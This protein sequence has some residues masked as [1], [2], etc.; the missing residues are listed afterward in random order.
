M[1]RTDAP[2]QLFPAPRQFLERSSVSSDPR[3]RVG[4]TG[5]E[6]QSARTGRQGPRLLAYWITVCRRS[7]ASPSD[8]LWSRAENV[9]HVLRPEILRP[10]LSY[11]HALLPYGSIANESVS[12]RPICAAVDAFTQI[13]TR[14]EMRYIFAGERDGLAVLGLRPAAAAEMQ[15]KAAEPRISIRSP[16]P[17]NHS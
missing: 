16:A 11:S 7:V 9:Y 14:L 5:D 15:R 6:H 10:N 4:R 2:I 13:L 8:W 3:S 17:M 1:L 12:D